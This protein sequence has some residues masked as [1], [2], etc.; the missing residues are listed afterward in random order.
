MPES[1]REE[2]YDRRQNTVSGSVGAP[3]HGQR[4]DRE[5]SGVSLVGEV[6]VVDVRFRVRIEYESVNGAG[7]E[8]SLLWQK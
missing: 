1:E 8:R 4:E 3:E 6:L 5:V 2:T 7:T